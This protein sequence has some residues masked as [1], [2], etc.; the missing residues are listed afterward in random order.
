MDLCACFDWEA[1]PAVENN[2]LFID[3]IEPEV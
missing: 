1:M 3:S 2:S